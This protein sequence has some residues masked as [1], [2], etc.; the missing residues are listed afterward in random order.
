MAKNQRG[1]PKGPPPDARKWLEEYKQGKHRGL[2]PT[3]EHHNSIWST[4]Y[5]ADRYKPVTLEVLAEVEARLGIGIPASLRDQLFIQNG[6]NL[7]ECDHYPF[8]DASV[9][10]T[11]ATVDGIEQAQSWERAS[12]DDWVAGVDDVD[13]L[14][15]LVVIA[16]HSESK[17]CLDYRKSGGSGI[18]AVT[19]VDVSTDPTE[20]R[21][22]AETADD[23]IHALVASRSNDNA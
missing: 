16:A 18:P 3:P 23:F 21:I 17:L 12:D 4:S 15:L 22:I 5:I 9:L 8:E 2:T 1:S 20:A 10:W 19:F 14:H 6:G 11:N 13:D 7:L